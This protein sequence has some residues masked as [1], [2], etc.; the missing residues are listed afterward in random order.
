VGKY[1][2]NG[3]MGSSEVFAYG[4][5]F[6][7]PTWTD[8]TQAVGAGAVWIARVLQ[9]NGLRNIF[10]PNIIHS[11]VRCVTYNPDGSTQSAITLAITPITGGSTSDTN[12][13][14]YEVSP[15]VT[16][17]TALASARGRGRFYLPPPTRSQVT[18]DGLFTSPTT[19]TGAGTTVGAMSEAWGNFKTNNPAFPVVISRAGGTVSTQDLTSVEVGNI[20]DA[21]R[22]RRNRLVEV[23]SSATIP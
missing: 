19:G 16:L 12:C 14:P 1:I 18:G 6:R 21:Q 4:W 20:P 8:A 17:R 2:F 3:T 22:R 5:G 7:S 23:R 9:V 15:C 11:S 13:L 10:V